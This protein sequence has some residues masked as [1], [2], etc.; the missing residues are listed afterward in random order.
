MEIESVEVIPMRKDSIWED[1]NT[2][3]GVGFITTSFVEWKL[4]VLEKDALAK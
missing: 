4:Y 2:G 3:F 1:V